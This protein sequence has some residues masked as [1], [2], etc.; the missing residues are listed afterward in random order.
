MKKIVDDER[1]IYKVC[2]LYYQDNMNQQEVG[3][4]LGVSRSSVLR[5]LQKG[6]EMGIVTIELHNPRFYDYGDLEKKLERAYGLK[7][8]LIVET[9]V[10][11]T[12]TEAASYMFGTASD[13]LHSFFKEGDRV[14]VA[15]GSTLNNV[16]STNKT[17]DKY[18]ELVFVA[19][20]GGISQSPVESVDVQ[21]NE[22]ARKFAE[23]FGGS[24]MQFL[25]PA[26]FSDKTVLEYFMKEK[27]V[28]YILDEFKKLNVIVVGIGVLD[29]VEH[30]LDKAGYIT[31]DERRKLVEQGA[32][33]D[34]C[35]Q[36][37]D[38]DG[39]T[40]RF[41]FFN[42]R[43]AAMRLEDIRRIPSKIGIAGRERKAEAVVGAIRGGYINILITDTECARKL[44]ELAKTKA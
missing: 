23:K 7:D 2:S 37:Y 42:D 34:M 15:M 21:G 4:F 17:Y 30:T 31:G 22:L 16:V 39:N 10:L 6:R 14:G 32:V 43:V 8:A 11:D 3:D 38:K 12:R 19:M 41:G 40:D 27:A 26:V 35:L 29:R 28:N 33:G 36:F 9:S 1:L 24:Y 5:M 44:I 20:E 25:S 13:Y 18:K